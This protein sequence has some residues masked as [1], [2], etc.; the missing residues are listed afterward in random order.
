MQKCVTL[1]RVVVQ[2]VYCY[3]Y[4]ITIIVVV[5]VAVDGF[6]SCVFFSMCVWLFMRKEIFFKPK[7]HVVRS[8]FPQCTPLPSL[9]P[10]PPPLSTTTPETCRSLLCEWNLRFWLYWTPLHER[11]DEDKTNWKTFCQ[12]VWQPLNRMNWKM[13]YNFINIIFSDEDAVTRI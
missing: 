13:F 8:F 7:L 4:H 1:P 10:P 12:N 11:R 9:P 5:D 6:Q 3:C 2:T